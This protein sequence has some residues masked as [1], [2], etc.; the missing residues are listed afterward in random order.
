[1]PV[2]ASDRRPKSG[3][4]QQLLVLRKPLLRLTRTSSRTLS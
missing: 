2:R 1:M 4:E 3:V